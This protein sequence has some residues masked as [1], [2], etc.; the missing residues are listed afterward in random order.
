MRF[1][2]PFALWALALL[3]FVI[4]A[5]LL[6]ERGARRVAAAFAS[7]TLVSS[8]ATARPGWRRHVGPALLL[9][10]GAALLVA[11]ATPEILL[12]TTRERATVILVVDASSSM[13]ATDVPPSRIAAARAAAR[14]FLRELPERFAV[15]AVAFSGTARLL[16]PP[17]T[18]RD[19]LLRALEYL[20]TSRGT[21]IGDGLA[22]AVR[23][24]RDEWVRDGR[25]PAAALLLSDG[26]DTGSEVPPADAAALAEHAGIAVHS[27]AL[28]DPQATTVTGYRPPNVSL[29]RSIADATGGTF[30]L[31]PTE[32][33][34]DRV[35]A[36]LGSRLGT[37]RRW[38][39]VS[40]AFVGAGLAI[41]IS[42][43]ALAMHWFRRP[44]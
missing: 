19:E 43:F 17:T 25:A 28:G 23:T 44:A 11:L 31:A 40:V 5:Y 2:F 37:T 1:Q 26:N 3:P 34:L 20:E 14:T 27:V 9:A 29:L 39:D 18:E 15:G 12:T 7:P 36:D 4:V 30:A 22:R 13:E 8:I 42:A 10:G 38:I 41:A 24:I 35:Y 21:L 16:V 6:R 32:D 33:A